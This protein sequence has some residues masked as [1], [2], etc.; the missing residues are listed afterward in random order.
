[1]NAIFMNSENSRN[2]KYH[3]SILK[4]RLNKI[5]FKKGRKKH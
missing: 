4:L 3:V 1:M 2:S 5:R